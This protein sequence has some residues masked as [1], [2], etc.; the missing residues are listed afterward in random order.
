[1][2]AQD[3]A[4]NAAANSLANAGRSNT[5]T[6][7]AVSVSRESVVPFSAFSRFATATAP[8]TVSHTGTSASTSIAF[9]LPEGESLSTALDAIDRTMLRIHVPAAIRGGTYGSARLFQ[10][11]TSSEPLLLLASFAAIYV[12]LGILYES[13]SHPLTILSTLPSA[14]VGALLALMLCG[15]DLSVIALIGIILLMG[16]VKKN[17]IMMIDFALEAERREGL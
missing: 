2:V 4:R 7:A 1:M 5:S 3:L 6:G 14:G 8:I 9:N 12:V 10:Q 16:I 11:N 15:Q 13:F 17:A